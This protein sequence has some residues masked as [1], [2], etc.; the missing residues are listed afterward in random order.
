MK[1]RE[2]PLPPYELIEKAVARDIEAMNQIVRAYRHY[3]LYFCKKNWIYDED[4][5]KQVEA[6]LIYA[7]TKFEIR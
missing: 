7:I 2:Y 1:K 5:V 4:L 3:M 6:K